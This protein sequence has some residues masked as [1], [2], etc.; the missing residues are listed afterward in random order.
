[1]I[2]PSDPRYAEVLDFLY[3]E[4]ELLDSGQFSEW[5]DLLTEDL[6]Y[7]M[8]L[9]VTHVRRT[10]DD[11]SHDSELLTETL[12]SLKLRVQRLATG[13]AWSETP[14]SRTR[15]MVTNVR[16]RAGDTANELQVAS[17]MLVYR[18]RSWETD[19]DIFCGERRDV[20]RRV[21]GSWKLAMRTI[22]LDQAVLGSRDVS[23]FF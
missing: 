20:L 7:R 17:N 15:H 23:I 5:L 2:S 9:H 10:E 12:A 6:T 18:N 3:L 13:Y 14:S 4:A 11:F 8:P 16:V 19:A 22:L 1:M 21:D